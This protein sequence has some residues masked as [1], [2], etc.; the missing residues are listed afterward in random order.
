MFF[1]FFSILVGSAQ[2]TTCITTT[3]IM[4]AAGR[5]GP[6]R[7]TW[8]LALR[9]DTPNG[10]ATTLQACR[11]I[12]GGG[13][14]EGVYWTQSALFFPRRCIAT[15]S[16]CFEG[17]THPQ[18]PPKLCICLLGGLLTIHSMQWIGAQGLLWGTRGPFPPAAAMVCF[19]C[20][21]WCW[22]LEAYVWW[23][24]CRKSNNCLQK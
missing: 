2:N 18:Q 6:L 17:H 10:W 13:G 19:G 16:E 22:P 7:P 14:I 20:V 24:H 23:T 12:W 15:T 21:G 9:M 3:T 11:C 4:A 8:R 1:A 5:N